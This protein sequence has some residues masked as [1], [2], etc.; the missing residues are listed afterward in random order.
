MHPA[1]S[2]GNGGRPTGP[3]TV[4]GDGAADLTANPGQLARRLQQVI[5]Q[6]WTASVSTEITPPQFVV[7]NSLRASP[8]IDQ[9]TLGERACLD[10]STVAD[11]V[12][13]LVQRGLIRRVRDPHDGRR[14]VL[15]LTTRG[16]STHTEVAQ[17]AE[18]MNEQLLAPL[19][20][21]DQAALITLLNRVVEAHPT[22]RSQ[23]ADA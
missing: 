12:A 20:G 1:H 6:L 22:G 3:S 7:L 18:A 16:E 11:V 5:H 2:A 17:R 8:D 4:A 19:S 23:P 15:R 21:D 13:R 9:R 14:N 10:R